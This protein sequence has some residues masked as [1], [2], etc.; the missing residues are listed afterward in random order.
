MFATFFLRRPVFAGVISIVLVLLGTLSALLL[1]VAQYPELAPPTIR[2]EA[3]YPGANARTGADTVATLVEQEVNGVDRMLY[4]SS[5]STSGR[6]QL[7]VTFELSTDVD[8]AAVQVQ[9]RVALAEPRL[10]EEVRRQGITVRK[11]STAFV[12]VVRA[13][14]KDGRYDDTYLSNFLSLRVKD[15]VTRIFGVGGVNV[16]PAKDY[17]MR[18][19]IDPQLLQAR[20]LTMQEVTDAIRGQNVEVAPGALGKQP[21]PKSQH[22]EYTLT[23][24]G[25]LSTP[26]EFAAIVV[27]RQPDGRLV[28]IGDVGRVEL[29]S[30]SYDTAASF[31]GRPSAV[32]IVNQL[33]G[34]NL[35][36]V[37]KLVRE[38]IDRLQPSFPPGMQVEFF[39]DGSMFIRAS[40]HEVVQTLIEAF[41][42]VFLVVLLFLRNWRATLI[43][44]LTIPVAI[45]GTFLFLAAFGFSINMLT[46]FGLVLAIGIVVDDAIVVVENVERNMAQHHLESYTATER[47]MHEIT[48]PVIAITL[49]LMAVFLPTAALPGITGAMYRQFALT[50]AASTALSALN[51]LSLSPALCALLLRHDRGRGP[52]FLRPFSWV[53]AAFGAAFELASRLYGRTVDLFVHHRLV[54][55][56]LFGGT[57]AFGGYSY[58]NLPG[59]FV[60]NE[61]LGFV[62]VNVQLPDAASF[63]RTRAVMSRIEQ[64]ARQVEGVD[65]ANSLS[66]FSILDGLGTASGTTFVVLKPW[67]ERTGRSA[68][69][70]VA[71]LQERLASLQEAQV[72]VF[73]LPPIRG[74]G[75][76]AGFDLRILDRAAAGLRALQQATDQV[77]GAAFGQPD[78]AVAFSSFRSD[79]P[80]LD[81][82]I[83]RDKALKLGVALPAIFDTLQTAIGSTYVNDFNMLDRTWRVHVQADA[84]FRQQPEDLRQ[85]RTRSSTGKMVPLGALMSVQDTTGPERITRYDL[86]PAAAVNGQARLGVSSGEAIRTMSEVCKATLPPGMGYA[87]SGLS[88][89]EQQVGHQGL[90]AFGMAVL[91]V[92]LI[93]SAQYESFVLPIAVVL[94]VPLVVV[95][96]ALALGLRAYDNNVFT[97]IGLV[98]LVGLGAKNA[99]LIVQFARVNQLHGMSRVQAALEAAK[100]RFRP[101]VMTSLA[102]VLGVT[103]LLFAT[104][105]GAGSR[106]ALGTVVFGGML[107]ATVLGVLF[108]P[109]LYVVVDR[110]FRGREH[111]AKAAPAAPS[112]PVAGEPPRPV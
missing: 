2:V 63:A 69:E 95:G 71:D 66:G 70:V 44:T 89:Q 23:T 32:L 87:W 93:L 64:I 104:G 22:F 43:P 10:P 92:Y 79:V 21:A 100:T 107:G 39:Y 72:L 67:D 58:A 41:L 8:I 50:I 105:A 47:S 3:A 91:L 103:P 106:R 11:Q 85:L 109:V 35:V 6:Y 7:D 37:A 46:M 29:Q 36:E 53:G 76:S 59:G 102:F 56:L 34:A 27:K 15:E 14:S 74:A 96:G 12:G 17:G 18:V 83:D 28:R 49:V 108:T 4:M 52:W 82:S 73:S 5:T 101:I 80:Q 16:L 38:T 48:G 42:L 97:Q 84:Q 61:D 68:D 62:V 78:I 45:L 99:I 88:Y 1:P 13:S 81:L 51:A 57:L 24:R 77:V 30:S 26:E 112:A 65:S 9:N 110:V 90:L 54:A 40:L 20:G 19:W 55:L 86:Y 111:G 25:R 98:L 75:N 33:P 94:S 60:P 31:A